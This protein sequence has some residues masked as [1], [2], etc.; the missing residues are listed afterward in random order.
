M[1]TKEI[2]KP[3]KNKIFLFI[4]L[5]VFGQIIFF[6]TIQDKIFLS[7]KVGYKLTNYSFSSFFNKFITIESITIFALSYIASCILIENYKN[8]KGKK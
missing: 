8:Y 3:T 2:F 7:P 5:M 1:K 6:S 4:I